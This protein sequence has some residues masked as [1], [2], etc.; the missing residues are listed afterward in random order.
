MFAKLCTEL[1]KSLTSR[2]EQVSDGN[3]PNGASPKA[4][5]Y[6]ILTSPTAAEKEAEAEASAAAAVEAALEAAAER[7]ELQD[8]NTAKN[9]EYLK[10]CMENADS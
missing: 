7:I 8:M 9:N 5:L 2:N 3:V 6:P 4:S 10:H 1:D